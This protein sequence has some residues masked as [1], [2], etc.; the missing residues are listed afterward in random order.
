MHSYQ[1][2]KFLNE[3]QNLKR[4]LRMGRNHQHWEGVAAKFLDSLASS[5]IFLSSSF[6]LQVIEKYYEDL[7]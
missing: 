3:F 2:M 1:D 4:G 5:V 6:L 7:A